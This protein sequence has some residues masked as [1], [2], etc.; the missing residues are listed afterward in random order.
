MPLKSFNVNSLFL[1]VNYVNTPMFNLPGWKSCNSYYAYGLCAKNRSH[2]MTGPVK[3]YQYVYLSNSKMTLRK[4]LVTTVFGNK[5]H[6]S[7]G[8][9]MSWI[10]SYRYTYFT[11]IRAW[12][13]CIIYVNYCV[14][15]VKW[16]QEIIAAMFWMDCVFHQ[17]YVHQYINFARDI[18]HSPLFLPKILQ[19]CFNVNYTNCR[20]RNCGDQIWPT[21]PVQAK[22]RQRPLKQT[23]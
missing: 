7:H 21:R 12:V 3:I 4:L 20:H 14:I 11:F 9:G 15:Y 23:F 8:H 16:F 22:N 10:F 17:S 5:W 1:D 18:H 13:R 6:T 2:Y 19:N